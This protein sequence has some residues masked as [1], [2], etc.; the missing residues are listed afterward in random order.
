M[1]T[2]HAFPVRVA[3]FRDCFSDVCTVTIRVDMS[4][5]GK[6]AEP[7]CNF[8]NAGFSECQNCRVRL[9]QIFMDDDYMYDPN[10]VLNPITGDRY[11][12]PESYRKRR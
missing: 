7:V 3:C 1:N 10:K 2:A 5:L 4:P 6:V 12:L 8:F 9:Q 11:P